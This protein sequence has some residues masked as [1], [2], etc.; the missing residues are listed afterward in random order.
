MAQARKTSS[1]AAAVPS[2]GITDNEDLQLPRQMFNVV[3][4]S[5]DGEFAVEW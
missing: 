4:E 2:S 5:L 3:Q 1:L